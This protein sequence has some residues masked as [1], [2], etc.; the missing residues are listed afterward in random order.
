MTRLAALLGV[1]GISRSAIFVRLAEVSL[2][3][4]ALASART[5]HH[6]PA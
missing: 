1:L 6:G 5:R 2:A 3:T 4:A